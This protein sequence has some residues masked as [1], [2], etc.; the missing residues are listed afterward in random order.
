MIER[1]PSNARSIIISLNPHSG[2]GDRQALVGNLEK[3]LTL[4]GFEVEVLTDLAQVRRR[5]AELHGVGSLRVVIGAGGDGTLSRLLNELPRETPMAVFPLGTENLMAKYLNHCSDPKEFAKLIAAGQTIRLDVGKANGCLFLIMAS[6]G[7]DADVVQR[8]HSK[9]SGHIRHWSYAR[10]ILESIGNYSYPLLEVWVDDRPEPIR[11]RWAFVFNVPRY[12]MNLS[13]VPDA[14]PTDGQLDLCTFREGKLL[15]GLYYLLAVITRRH[16]FSQESQFARFQKLRI[17]VK[18]A[19]AE[20]PYQLDGD[21]GGQLPLEI[22]V[23]PK[24]FRVVVSTA[25]ISQNT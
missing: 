14:N 18:D 7:F 5:A 8:L 20:V 3:C 22:I 15:R 12:A 21:P 6:C 16:R 1:L 25:W 4:G 9:R 24:Y 17:N 11:A 19:G 2:A 23:Q 10:P 13:I